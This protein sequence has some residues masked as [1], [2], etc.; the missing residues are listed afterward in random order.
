MQQT[1]GFMAK[2][3]PFL[4]LLGGELSPG[5]R[6]ASQIEGARVIA[7]DG[8]MRHAATLDL[9]PELWVGDFD[10]SD[11]SLKSR[12]SGVERVEHPVA[13]DMTDGELAIEAALGRGADRLIF[14][15]A[16]GGER[17]DHALQ[18]LLLGVAAARG[19]GLPVLMTSGHEEAWPVLPGSQ[20]LDL[21][22]GSLFSVLA[23]SDLEEL[24]LDG[25]KW[26]LDR[27][28]V[29]MGHSLTLSNRVGPQGGGIR[30]TLGAGTGV[31]LARPYDLTG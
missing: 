15:G 5:P 28:F 21:P 17:S 26:P 14:A 18:N 1:G 13:K 16:L 11:N 6:L 3:T 12:F 27:H 9:V 30:V 29:P 20:T 10:S 8:G 22:E 23:L 31:L 19:H 4:I 2:T 25:V 7:A 24:T